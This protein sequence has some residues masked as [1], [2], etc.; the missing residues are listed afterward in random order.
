MQRMVKIKLM[1]DSLFI[2]LLLSFLIIIGLLISFS[3]FSFSFFRNII[4]DEII[5]YNNSN[6]KNTTEGFEKHFELLNNLVLG[7]Y[8]NDQIEFLLNAKNTDYYT[9]SQVSKDLRNTVSNPLLY[10]DNIVLYFKEN[11]FIIEKTGSTRADTMFSKFYHTNAYPFDF[12][13]N[14]FAQTYSF[15]IYPAADF[16]EITF[17]EASS[18]MGRLFPIMVKN[19][20]SPD[21]YITAFADADKMIQAYH[22][23][24]NDNF[25]ILDDQGSF[26]YTSNMTDEKSFPSLA[27]DVKGNK[28]YAQ[29][30]EYYYFYKKGSFTG[31]IYVNIIPVKNISS[32]V[33]R[34][35]YTLITLLVIAVA[36]S[37]I[38]SILFSMQIHNPVKQILYSM[39]HFNTHNPVRSRIKEFQH[40]QSN[41]T[42]S[43]SLLRNY[44]FSNKL[45]KI[46]SNFH[47]IKDLL[48]DK[49][50]FIFILFQFTFK[51]RLQDE[52]GEETDR[53]TNYLKEYISRTISDKY[54][55][56]CTFQI[57]T[58]QI[59]SLIFPSHVETELK[60]MLEQLENVLNLDTDFCYVTI[61]VSD[62]HLHS[63]ELTSSYEQV[64][65]R[66]QQ[67]QLL[68]V[69]QIIWKDR[70]ETSD[71]GLT[72]TL[73]KEFDNY[74]QSGNDLELIRFI[75][76]VFSAMQKK[77]AIAADYLRMAEHLTKKVIRA[78]TE[79][80]MEHALFCST[81]QLSDR[82]GDCHH[83]DQLIQFL[84]QFMVHSANI[85]RQKKEARD[86]I[87]SFVY[88]YIENHY[89]EELSL[90]SVAEK[91]NISGGYL[92]SYFKEKTGK[93]FI[94][95][96]NEVRID[97]TKEF[98]RHSNIKIH[99]AA[100]KAGYQNM[101]SF[102]RMFKKFT[103]LTPSEYRQTNANSD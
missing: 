43:N 57:E 5:Q 100:I 40:I 74:L 97:K 45:K 56:A 94:D 33:T 102:N 52:F 12:W 35:N 59:L 46:N 99:E 80:N 42:N 63:S 25:L 101:N 73:E 75:R 47:D 14:Q 54:T 51:D 55:D 78:V 92:S 68:D 16:S 1:T 38:A 67:R 50:P 2:R 10:L 39:Q 90:D 72:S 61:A 28:H 88:E 66:I 58:S 84:E 69:T 29:H 13:K 7:L 34:L 65:R 86:L 44:A 41:L 19:R 82:L 17:N 24:I 53:A 77:N 98:L 21:F 89:S 27:L 93:N 31:L 87:T 18:S 4:Q 85:V 32:Q 9:S 91:M 15:R 36:I 64:N 83:I 76:K 62:V 23:S 22:R 8:M 71:L 95:Y 79:I 96:L 6:L 70:E 60:G 26:L 103:G 49:K 81:V 20:F 11:S 37:I 30:G 48:G 3:F